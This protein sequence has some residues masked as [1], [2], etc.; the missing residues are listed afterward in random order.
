MIFMD[1]GRFLSV[2]SLIRKRKRSLSVDKTQTASTHLS[3]LGILIAFGFLTAG[4]GKALNWIDFDLSTSGVLSW[5]YN[6]YFTL[7]RD[8]LLA[9]YAIQIESRWLWEITDLSGVL[10][11]LGF[12]VALFWRRA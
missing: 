4:Y 8:E 11:E 12:L 10:F 6:S 2:D 5:L 3:M 9:P 1:W 7:G